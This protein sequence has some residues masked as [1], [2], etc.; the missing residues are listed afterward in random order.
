MELKKK[1]LRSVNSKKIA[2][3]KRN[4]KIGGKKKQ[5]THILLT[6]VAGIGQ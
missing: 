1:S 3:Q 5:Q 6:A 2:K 4:H